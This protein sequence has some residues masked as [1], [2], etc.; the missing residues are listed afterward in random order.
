MNA[1]DPIVTLTLNPAIDGFCE[2]ETVRPIHKI[3][4]RGEEYHPGGGGLNVARVIRDLGGNALA[5]YLAGGATG[6]VLDELIASIGLPNRRIAIEGHTRISQVVLERSSG[7]EYRFVAE[8]PLVS[9]AEFERCRALLAET[10]CDWLVLSGSVPR[11]IPDAAYAELI[12][13]AAQRG[14]H[15]VLDASGP[16]LK[17][18]LDQGGLALI[19]PSHG[20]F[21]SLVGRK[22]ADPDSIAAEAKALALS[23]KAALV[24]VTLG[25]DGAILASADGVLQFHAPPVVG[26]S[27]VGAGDSFVGAMVLALARGMSPGDAFRRGMAAGSAAVMRHGPYLCDPVDVER[28]YREIV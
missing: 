13:A 15:C 16:A 11:G 10:H 9:A 1:P 8:G 5:V 3:R 4:T 6:I 26:R 28:L 14:T 2:A 20:E 19:K 18:A 7:L 24:A 21:E 17:L 22:L 23:G 25:K 27:A 12:S